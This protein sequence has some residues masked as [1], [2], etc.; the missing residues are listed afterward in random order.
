M[1]DQEMEVIYQIAAH[2]K[3]NTE[4]LE[5]KLDKNTELTEK[6]LV[7]AT[8]TNGRVTALEDKMKNLPEKV[9]SQGNKISWIIGIGSAVCVLAGFIY[10]LVIKD[11]NNTIDNFKNTCCTEKKNENSASYNNT[12]NIR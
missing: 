2:M 11:I 5:A 9:E 8:Y 1:A 10:M 7:Q 6:V 4:R 12:V 3:E